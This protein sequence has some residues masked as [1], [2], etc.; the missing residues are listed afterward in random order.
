MALTPTELKQAFYNRLKSDSAG[1]AVRNALGDG[2]SSVVDRSKLPS[3]LPTP[4]F[5]VLWWNSQPSGGARNRGVKVFYPSWAIYDSADKGY[6][7]IEALEALI[8]AAYPEDAIKMCFTD[9]L[10]VRDLIDMKLNALP[11]RS[12][13]FQI[14]TRG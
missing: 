9:F 13:A 10:P 11:A 3:P 14:R 8:Q 7:R 1:S 5:V 4:P 6:Y 2:A 12:M